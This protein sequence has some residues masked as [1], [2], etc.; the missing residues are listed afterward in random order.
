[1]KTS[2]FI[3]KAV[4]SYL[5]YTAEDRLI[6]HRETFLCACLQAQADKMGT[7]EAHECSKKAKAIIFTEL[8]AA[9]RVRYPYQAPTTVHTIGIA[10]GHAIRNEELQCFR[11]MYAEMLACYFE[12][13]DD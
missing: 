4:D 11:F 1:M 12:S 7:L 10:L 2:A 5:L 3:R 8:E 6:G 13:I 9:Y